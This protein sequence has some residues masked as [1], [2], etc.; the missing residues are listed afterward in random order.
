[1][2]A[3]SS[4]AAQL[5]QTLGIVRQNFLQLQQ[6]LCSGPSSQAP[7][8]CSSSHAAPASRHRHRQKQR[9]HFAP[10]LAAIGAGLWGGP[11]KQPGGD[12]A[13]KGQGKEGQPPGKPGSSSGS[14]KEQERIPISEVSA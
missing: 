7:T 9:V 11:P 5:Q 1:M 10:P 12:A 3:V 8:S 2:D 14:S 6:Q 13:G 4:A